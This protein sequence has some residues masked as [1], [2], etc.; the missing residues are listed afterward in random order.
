MILNGIRGKQIKRIAEKNSLPLIIYETDNGTPDIQYIRSILQNRKEIRN[1]VLNYSDMTKEFHG[2]FRELALTCK[3]YNRKLIVEGVE[4]KKIIKKRL[5][6]FE[7]EVFIG[8]SELFDNTMLKIGFAIVKK[9]YPM[10]LSDKELVTTYNFIDDSMPINAFE[11]FSCA[12]EKA[13]K[14]KSLIKAIDI[15]KK[16]ESLLV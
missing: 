6:L 16:K 12:V 8:N 1:V 5:S 14:V 3:I 7:P 10:R 4:N 15:Y 13:E 2:V 9:D 11:S